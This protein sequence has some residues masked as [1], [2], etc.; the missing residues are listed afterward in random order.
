M[1][2]PFN[3]AGGESEEGWVIGGRE[4]RGLG[5]IWR[6]ESGRTKHNGG[7]RRGEADADGV[8]CLPN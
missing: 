1:R 2:L 8:E 7:Q 4:Q 5:L 3:R 6:R